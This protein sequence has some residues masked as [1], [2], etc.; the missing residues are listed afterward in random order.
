MR[1]SIVGRF[2][3]KLVERDHQVWHRVQSHT[4][5]MLFCNIFAVSVQYGKFLFEFMIEELDGYS[6]MLKCVFTFGAVS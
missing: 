6:Q 1:G 5:A 3:L 2:L 4:F